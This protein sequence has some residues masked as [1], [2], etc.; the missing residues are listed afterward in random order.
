[1]RSPPA[2]LALAVLLLPAPASAR[3]A[4]AGALLRA[5]PTA[6]ERN[7]PRYERD[8]FR[9]WVDAD[10][11]GCTT[12]YE[13]LHRQNS[14]RTSDGCAAREGRWRSAY[15]GASYSS[16]SHLDVDHFIPLKEAW[17]SGAR[18]WSAGTRMRFANDVAYR[19][20]L[21]AVSARTNRS[22]GHRDPAEWTP[23]ATRYRCRY[24]MTWVAVKY[25]WQ[26]A[27]NAAERRA[28]IRLMRGCPRSII[29]LPTPPRATIGVPRGGAGTTA[30]PRGAPDRDSAAAPPQVP[31]RG[32]QDC[33]SLPGPVRVLPGDPDR[34]DGDGDGIGCEG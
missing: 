17:V 21:I 12:R 19:G 5:L 32:D 28:L 15:D 9:H 16:S 34:L 13:V 22:K 29:V 6:G 10:G 23:P 33:S 20:S 27:V 4:Y 30:A 14:R 3:G 1:M 2:L 24:A 31:R 7:A 25:R 8:Y 18:R 11:D 26:L